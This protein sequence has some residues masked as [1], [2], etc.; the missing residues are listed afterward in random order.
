MCG[1]ISQAAQLFHSAA[2]GR[3]HTVI[4][5]IVW[6][7]AVRMTESVCPGL[8]GAAEEHRALYDLRQFVAGL[9]VN[10]A[11]NR[12]APHLTASVKPT[13]GQR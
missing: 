4:D 5:D 2:K 13:S 9:L 11:H 12:P 8:S 6:Q 7:C 3:G 1:V 10:I